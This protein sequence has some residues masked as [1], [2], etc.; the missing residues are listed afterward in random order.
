MA[1]QS[2]ITIMHTNDLHSHFENWPK[3]RRYLSGQKEILGLGD[4]GVL[5]VDIGDALDL[6]HPLTEATAGTINVEL[7]NQIG[8]DA[9]TIGNNEG[10]SLQHDKLQKLY[11]DANFPVTVANIKDL[12]TNKQPSWCQEVVYRVMPDG[13]KVA[14]IGM[15]AP[16]VE[17]YPLREWGIGEVA[18]I[19]AAILPQIKVQADVIILLSHL[20]LSED[21]R[22]AQMFPTLDVIIGAH[23]HHRLEKGEMLNN[24]L[25][26]A[27]G[28]WGR[29]IG[30]ISL[31]IENHKVVSKVARLVT[32]SDLPDEDTDIAE[33]QGLQDAGLEQLRAAKVA[34]LPKPLLRADNSFMDALFAMLVQ[35]T[36]IKAALL[37]TGLVLG[38][39]PAGEVTKADLLALLPHQMYVMQTILTG[40]ELKRLLQEIHKNAE[41]VSAFAM[42]GLGFR[43]KL[44]GDIQLCEMA[45]DI[46][47]GQLTYQ[48]QLIDDNKQYQ[49]VSLDYYKYL[50]FFPTIDLVG[51]NKIMMQKMLREDFADYLAQNFPIK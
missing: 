39:L 42:V 25:I 47:K 50:P 6:V 40:K 3:I 36:G 12:R 26:A 44:V 35:K 20:G 31:T 15:T 1:E 4:N 14:M 38:D 29:Y 43:G 16:F 17:T 10:L 37:S 5:T 19:L 7:L 41:F 24:T 21:R 33:I 51:E 48:N 2:I 13:T 45:I 18:P 23:T 46:H 30:K 28:K 27:A 34:Y 32:T 22:L 11:N 49:F 9:V 8:Y